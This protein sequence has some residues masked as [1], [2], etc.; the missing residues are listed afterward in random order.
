M[1]QTGFVLL[2]SRQELCRQE[3]LSYE[4][5]KSCAPEQQAGSVQA[6]VLILRSRK[7]LL[8][9]CCAPEQ[10]FCS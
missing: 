6:G 10:E 4:A 2:S 1:K 3:F 9:R 8:R 5:S 7:G